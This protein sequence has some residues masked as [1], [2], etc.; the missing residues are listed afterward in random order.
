[1]A[2]IHWEKQLLYANEG[3]PVYIG[4]V[5]WQHDF[6]VH[7]CLGHLVWRDTDRIISICVR[8]PK[9]RK[10]RGS[11]FVYLQMFSWKTSPM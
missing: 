9:V 1:M 6:A 2:A 8:W 5:L 7:T 3:G 4:E 11:Q 10:P